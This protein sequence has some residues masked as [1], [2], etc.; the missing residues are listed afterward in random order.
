[1]KASFSGVS[2]QKISTK[3]N[4]SRYEKQFDRHRLFFNNLISIYNTVIIYIDT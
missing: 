4:L 1:M 2:N 3:I